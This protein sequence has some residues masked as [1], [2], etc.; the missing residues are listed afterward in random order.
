MLKVL[1]LDVSSKT[2]WAVIEGEQ[3]G[4]TYL[5]GCGVIKLGKTIDQCGAYPWSYVFAAQDM[6]SKIKELVER[7]KPEVIVIEE[8]NKGK[9][10][11]SQKF[12]EFTH[13]KILE[14]LGTSVPLF[15]VNSSAWRKTLG[16]ELTKADRKNNSKISTAKKISRNT[17]EG[18]HKV[19]K[20]LGVRG[21][22]G[23]KHLAVRFVNE[24]YELQLK[25][26][27]NDTADAI[28]LGTA[29]LRGSPVCDGK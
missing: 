15:Y 3:S 7:I 5:G 17:G 28:C 29:Y 11:Y 4:Q 27:D 22:I 8:T 20:A 16:I 6:A 19:K 12:L 18:V 23:K 10:R 25:Q 2:G 1:A 24:T 9:N 21:R 13:I 14:S 26:K